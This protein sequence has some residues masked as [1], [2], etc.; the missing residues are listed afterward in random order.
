MGFIAFLYL[1][2]KYHQFSTYNHSRI[3]QISFNGEE[4]SIEIKHKS[5]TLKTR[6]KKNSAGELKAPETGNMSRRIKE[7]NDS[8][9]EVTLLENNKPVIFQET[10]QR[11]GLEIVDKIFNYL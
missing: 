5:H 3:S 9:V 6:V 7:S 2:G 8:V 10:G 4:L 11:A 1:D